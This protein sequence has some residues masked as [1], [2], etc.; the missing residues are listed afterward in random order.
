M[1]RRCDLRL[2]SD[3]IATV[4][5]AC[6]GL[7]QTRTQFVVEALVAKLRDLGVDPLRPRRPRRKRRPQAQ[8]QQRA[9]AA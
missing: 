7:S 4:D 6:E 9:E 5:F 3:L 2:S 1:R 8:A